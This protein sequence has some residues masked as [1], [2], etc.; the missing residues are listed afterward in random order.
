MKPF[1]LGRPPAGWSAFQARDTVGPTKVSTLI[2]FLLKPIGGKYN[3]GA[4]PSL[5]R[6]HVGAT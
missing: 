2:L 3:R 4:H 5:N 6:R 1:L